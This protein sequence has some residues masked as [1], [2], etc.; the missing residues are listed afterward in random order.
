MSLFKYIDEQESRNTL[1]PKTVNTP[2]L[3]PLPLHQRPFIS[4]GDSCNAN[5]SGHPVLTCLKYTRHNITV[6]YF[7]VLHGDGVNTERV[8]YQYG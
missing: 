4:V 1:W 5:Q 3:S 7:T 2:V 8:C 6:F